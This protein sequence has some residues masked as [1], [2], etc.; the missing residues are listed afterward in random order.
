M[1]MI[2]VSLKETFVTAMS[3]I[4]DRI[5]QS[6]GDR[7]GDMTPKLHC[8]V[9]KVLTVTARVAQPP[10]PRRFLQDGIAEQCGVVCC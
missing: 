8:G 7:L 6:C 10:C 9:T 4:G 2:D 5:D 1:S 3:K